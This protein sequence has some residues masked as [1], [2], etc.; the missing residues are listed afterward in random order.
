MSHWICWVVIRVL[1][2]TEISLTTRPSSLKHKNPTHNIDLNYHNCDFFFFFVMNKNKINSGQNQLVE[3]R[4]LTSPASGHTRLSKAKC[5]EAFSF[6]LHSRCS[7]K[8]LINHCVYNTE[9]IQDKLWVVGNPSQPYVLSGLSQESS[10]NQ[11]RED[12]RVQN[13]LPIKPVG[14]VLHWSL[15]LSVMVLGLTES[16]T[17]RVRPGPVYAEVRSF[18]IAR[19]CTGLLVCP[20][21]QTAGHVTISNITTSPCTGYDPDAAGSGTCSHKARNRTSGL[22][23]SQHFGMPNYI[24]AS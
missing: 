9:V 12:R 8:A 15:P 19:S 14:L 10:L 1:T 21:P 24:P 11:D 20:G 13:L 7:F 22:C 3:T 17:K 16:I 2:K 6:Q 18:V 23:C 5:F 4:L